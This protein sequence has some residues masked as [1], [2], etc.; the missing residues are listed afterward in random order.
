MEGTFIYFVG[1]VFIFNLPVLAVVST[2]LKVCTRSIFYVAIKFVSSTEANVCTFSFIIVSVVF[3][4]ASRTDF[5]RAV[6]NE[7][8]DRLSH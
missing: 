1:E 8:H 2:F 3:T 7:R 5:S 6:F 4:A